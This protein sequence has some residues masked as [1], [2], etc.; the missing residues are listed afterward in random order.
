MVNVAL[1]EEIYEALRVLQ[2]NGYDLYGSIQP[3]KSSFIETLIRQYFGP[4]SG[5]NMGAKSIN[6][7]LYTSA[8][9]RE[10]FRGHIAC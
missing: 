7:Q 8:L 10:T 2:K 5:L 1:E 6:S 9:K 4:I 3:S